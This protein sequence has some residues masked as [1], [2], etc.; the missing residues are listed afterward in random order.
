MRLL[1]FRRYH[2]HVLLKEVEAIKHG[3]RSKISEA[4]RNSA[5]MFYTER[6]RVLL[7]GLDTRRKPGDGRTGRGSAGKTTGLK[8]HEAT[9]S[10]AMHKPPL[11]GP[12]VVNG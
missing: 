7:L 2:V 4:D 5:A 10:N 8:R 3:M 9:H 6:R 11:L 12:V 1:S